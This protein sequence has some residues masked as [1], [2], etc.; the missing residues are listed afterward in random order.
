MSGKVH[1]IHT[2]ILSKGWFVAK[3]LPDQKVCDEVERSVSHYLFHD[4][5]EVEQPRTAK[6]IY[7]LTMTTPW[8][9]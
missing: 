7:K 1:I 6:K 9:T 3:L 5:V 4:Q 8:S 2:F